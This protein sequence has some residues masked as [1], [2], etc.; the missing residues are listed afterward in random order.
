[1]EIRRITDAQFLSAFDTCYDDFTLYILFSL[2]T[3]Q[4]K[5]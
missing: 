4:L 2:G 5:I 3:F 1:M